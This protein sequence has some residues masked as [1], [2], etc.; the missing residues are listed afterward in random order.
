M[1]AATVTRF[2]GPEVFEVVQRPDPVPGRGEV[3]IGVEVADTLWLETMVRSG[4]GQA[5]WP[6]RPP[7]V[8]GNGVA[9][10]ITQV[11]DDVDRGLLGRRV[12]A[13]T[14]SEGGYADRAV[15]PVAAVSDVPDGLDLT[16][17]AAL[18][19]DGPTALALFD[20]TKVGPDDT[21]LVIGA[22]G[23]L[24]VLSVQLGRARAARVVA[25]ARGA[26]LGRVR[27]LGPAAVIDS[28]Q[29]DWPGQARAAL[30]DG[31]AD[32]VLDNIG[33]DLGEASFALVAPGGRFSAHG[34]PSGRFARLSQ[35]DQRA[36]D[37]RGITVTG[38]GAVQMPD[39]DLKRY[40]DEALRAAAT[41]TFA[42]VI[43]QIFPLGQAGSAHAAIEGRDVFGKT[44]L[45]TAT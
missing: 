19:H 15:V 45:T 24:G 6:M 5:Y 31:G 35:A 3:V 18:L 26:K 7:Y 14:G 32:V 2:G 9:G 20:I 42:P 12:V 4:A 8:P 41:G 25:I 39:S 13:H 30:P 17:A 33:G 28:E 43:G 23:G 36:A 34:T 29:P 10:R 21:V 22:S 37:R 44:I 27:E 11:G 1:R 16:V 38:I 40:T